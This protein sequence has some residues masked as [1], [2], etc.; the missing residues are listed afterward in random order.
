MNDKRYGW[1]TTRCFPR[2]MEDAFKHIDCGAE[3]FFPPEKKRGWKDA[4]TLAVAIWL[5]IG[6]AYYLVNL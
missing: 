2:T 3:W 4:G 6:L 5:W 1:P